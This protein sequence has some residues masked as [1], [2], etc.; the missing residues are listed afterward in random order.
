MSNNP[1]E[2]EN[3][4][5]L[6]EAIA[7]SLLEAERIVSVTLARQQQ[8]APSYP[9]APPPLPQPAT[10]PTI[11][12]ELIDLTD[13]PEPE[14]KAEKTTYREPP[15]STFDMS[16]EEDEHS[17]YVKA[18]SAASQE[19]R[20][21]E[22]ALERSYSAARVDANFDE[23]EGNEDDMDDD[24]RKA[25]ELSRAS[26]FST[27]T[28]SAPTSQGSSLPRQPQQPVTTPPQATVVEKAISSPASIFG[29]SR[30]DMERE[31]QERI[32]K[33]ALSDGAA[34]SR[35]VSEDREQKRR[36]L[37]H[38]ASLSTN[39]SSNTGKYGS[40]ASSI[41]SASMPALSPS[42]TSSPTS[43]RP[44]SSPSSTSRR[45]ASSLSSTPLSPSS[46]AQLRQ[47]SVYS[48]PR[49]H[50]MSPSL[51]STSRA[52][53]EILS[54]ST[55]YP[56]KYHTA[57]FRNTYIRGTTP[58]KWDVRFRDLVNKEHLMKAVVTAMDL[59]EKWLEPYLPHH[60]P[61][62]RVVYQKD[63]PADGRPRYA[64]SEKMMYVHPRIQ[65]FGTFHAKLM[66]LFYPLFCRIVVSSANLVEHD[67]EF[68][69]NTLY[70]QDFQHL[71][72]VDSAEQLGDFGETLID[73]LTKMQVPSKIIRTV[74]RVNFS[75]A[76]VVLIPAVNGWH[77]VNN[78][79]HTYGIARLAKVM[80]TVTTETQEWDLEYQTSSL[81]KL[82]VKFLGELNRAFRG[83]T[84]RA[85]VTVDVDERV[86]PIKLIFPTKDHIINSELGEP[87]AGTV[88]LRHEFWNQ[89]TFPRVVMHDFELVGRHK[90][91]LM[92]TK[93]IL[94]KAKQAPQTLNRRAPPP[95]PSHD[96]R[97]LAGWF[98]VGSANCTESAWGTMANKRS[99]ALQGLCINIRNWE[100]GVVYMIETEEEMEEFNRRYRGSQRGED[101]EPDQTFFG[102][103]PVPYQ[104]PLTPYYAED[105]AWCDM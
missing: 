75:P 84:P 23:Q 3:D 13:D 70:V 82:T 103:L 57:T 36:T 71:P 105:D 39:D 95:P 102:P 61:Q 25:L 37:D 49:G 101:D 85:R 46:S 89:R 99:G 63:I 26:S 96:P 97:K 64:K 52:S 35:D 16:L 40:L 18:L 30:A 15:Q 45:P 87:G 20:F 27:A 28:S 54:A 67:W 93:T 66:I 81:G 78:E 86:P 2:Y 60:I 12:I 90:G 50:P 43:R 62:C 7:L 22:S 104:R 10:R 34:V 6:A 94:A 47:Q 48:A 98:Y 19:I 80:Q 55:K 73:Y 8:A 91:Y 41:S 17:Q 9:M 53:S 100:L 58:G 42:S 83:F 65:G 14:V 1:D 4:P 11:K 59:E 21:Q 44:A 38:S 88:C 92:H 32:K 74:K 68:L 33:R 24:F 29:I 5:D 76:K 69:V 72:S 79:R 51:P 31:R 56:A 77:P